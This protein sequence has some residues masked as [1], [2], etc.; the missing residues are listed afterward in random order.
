MFNIPQEVQYVLKVLG[1]NSYLVGGCVRDIFLNKQPKDYDITTDKL[2]HE[3][4]QLFDHVIETGL[5][6]GT[7]TTIINTMPIEIT[8][9]RKD[10][11]YKDFRRPESVEFTNILKED[12]IRR[13][14]TINA[15]AMDIYGRIYD[16]VDSQR[17]LNNGVIKAVGNPNDRINEDALRMMRA[18]RFACQLGFDIDAQTI[19]AI[20]YNSNLIQNISIER[21]REELNK[22][23]I[24]N[25]PNYGIKILYNSG[26][27][28][29]VLPEL[30]ECY[31]FNQHNP[32]HNKDVFQHTLE[33]LKNTPNKLPLRLGALLHDI[34]KPKCFSIDDNGIGHFY[35]H[36]LIGADMSEEILK[37][38]KFDNKTIETVTILVRYHMDRYDS[39]RTS[40]IKK[41]IN[42]VGKENLNDLFELQI[43]DVKGSK[44]PYDYSGIE[45]LR[46]EVQEI[47]SKKEPLSI[48]DL[49][50]NGYDLIQLGFKPSK[51]M[52]NILNTLLELVLENPECNKKEILIENAI[53]LQNINA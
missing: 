23:L 51:E 1:D 26:L 39:L 48:K 41:F 31:N 13:D 38:M 9:M 19:E 5:Q 34:G 10:G 36:H 12:L 25:N 44:P 20:K 2:P 3:V 49:D 35:K 33:V 22:I 6:H 16:C 14:Y 7:V 27:L 8:T 24:S 50:I 29:Y 32:N 15:M 47:L 45:K 37:R 17:D 40:N 28:Q 11:E 21:I 43:S 52:G 4:I 46:F 30:C 18:I 42:R 53:Q